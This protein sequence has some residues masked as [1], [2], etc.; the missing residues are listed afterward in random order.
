MLNFDS[1]K[2]VFKIC[3]LSSLNAFQIFKLFSVVRCLFL[4]LIKARL[5]RHFVVFLLLLCNAHGFNFGFALVQVL[6]VFEHELALLSH[7]R[8]NLYSHILQLGFHSLFL[9]K[10]HIFIG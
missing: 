8:V 4:R 7:Q 2:F 6:V 3:L 1:L 9:L 10:E 5:H